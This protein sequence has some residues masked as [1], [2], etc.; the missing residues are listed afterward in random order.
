M[1]GET[2]GRTK[3]HL[4]IESSPSAW[5]MCQMAAG[6]APLD[7]VLRYAMHVETVSMLYRLFIA[8]H[9]LKECL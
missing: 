2:L 7:A 1:A 4:D 8:C 6:C 3:D 5:P 9:C